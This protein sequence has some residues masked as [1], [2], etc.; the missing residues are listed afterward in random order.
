MNDG[1]AFG[2]Q[3]EGPGV[4]Q[5]GHFGVAV[6]PAQKSFAEKI[7]E[8]PESK[9]DPTELGNQVREK[10]GMTLSQLSWT[11]PNGTKQ[12]PKLTSSRWALFSAI[13]ATLLPPPTTD[14]QIEFSR[15]IGQRYIDSI[16][17]LWFC[18]HDPE[19]WESPRPGDVPLMND[20]TALVRAAR[21]WADVAVPPANLD[22]A[23]NLTNLLTQLTFSAI[24]VARG[25]S[26]ED[27]PDDSAKKNAQTSLLS[28]A[29]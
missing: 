3:P 23:V 18:L 27:V 5:L 13:R 11:F 9:P 16:L 12:H 21:E 6:T 14:T 8:E 25:D 1:N 2:F 29:T 17:L 4:Q 24:P 10:A 19:V 15:I 22:D 20:W 7:A 28:H 26:G